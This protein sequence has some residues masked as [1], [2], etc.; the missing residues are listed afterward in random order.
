[1]AA[2]QLIGEQAKMPLRPATRDAMQD[3]PARKPAEIAA[4]DPLPDLIRRA[5]NAMATFAATIA[6]EGQPRIDEAVTA[7]AWSLYKPETA[8]RLAELAVEVT[9]IG[10]VESKVIKNQR[11]TF[12]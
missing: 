10:D 7:L 2:C 11:K 4:A 5:R 6:H 1:R 12:G 3:T 9:G 8:R